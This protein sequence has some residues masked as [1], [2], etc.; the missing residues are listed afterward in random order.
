MNGYKIMADSYRKALRDNIGKGE[1]NEACIKVFDMLAEFSDTDKYIAFDSGMFNEIFKGY[2]EL[3][4]K[5]MD[6]KTRKD[7]IDR[8]G[9]IL[10]LYNSQQAEEYYK[11]L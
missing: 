11:Q 2:V 7:I 5:D 3:L 8:S 6:D 9:A 4:V 10:D 1:Y